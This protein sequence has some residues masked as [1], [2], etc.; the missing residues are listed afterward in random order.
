[1]RKLQI[2]IPTFQGVRRADADHVEPANCVPCPYASKARWEWTA[3]VG[4]ASRTVVRADDVDAGQS[5]RQTC[6][7]II[8]YSLLSNR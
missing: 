2:A 8:R 1:M 4:H 6:E 7:L 3:Q 5:Q